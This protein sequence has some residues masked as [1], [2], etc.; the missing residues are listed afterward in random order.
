MYFHEK[1]VAEKINLLR[2]SPH[3]IPIIKIDAAFEWLKKRLG[4]D[5]SHAQKEAVTAALESKVL[6]ITGGPGTG[7]TTLLKALILILEAKKISYVLA[8]PTGRAAKRLS[9]ATGREAKTIHRLLEYSPGSG[10]FQ[11]GPDR[12]LETDF[13]II[14]EVSMVDIALMNNLLRAI[15]IHATVILVGD[16]DQLPSVGPG[17]VLEDLIESEKLP[18]VR[19]GTIFR[20]AQSSLIITNAHLVNTGII[21][22][23]SGEDPGMKQDCFLIEKE[24]PEECLQLIKEMVGSRIPRRFGY[25]PLNDVQILCPMHRGIL[26]TENLNREIREILNSR[27]LQI[28]GDRFRVGDRVMQVKN[29]YDKEVFN[30]DIGMISSYDEESE[31]VEIRYEDRLVTYHISELDEIT[32]A[33]AVTIHKSQGS[34]YKAVIIPLATQHFVMLRRNLLYTAMTRGREL[35]IV[36]GSSKALQIAVENKYTE[37]RF[38][39]LAQRI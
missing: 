32:P 36:I 7:K 2:T 25:D 38:S 13:I 22:I 4:V 11:R 23:K 17:K 1:S 9:E 10:G 5:L 24:D 18:V 14:D 37:P 16:S 19:L 35:V 15:N 6:V 34:E 21:P 12:P 3:F 30:G 31:E 8:A 26:G 39:W 28:R 33:Y 27:G 20:Q 29:D